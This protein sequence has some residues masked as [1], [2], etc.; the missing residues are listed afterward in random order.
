LSGGRRRR[1]QRQ[2]IARH[3]PS[4]RTCGVAVVG[5]SATIRL[6]P[7]E[8]TDPGRYRPRGGKRAGSSAG[9]GGWN[10]VCRVG[11]GRAEAGGQGREEGGWFADVGC[12]LEG[13][14]GGDQC[15]LAP[16]AAEE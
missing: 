1:R 7:R 6:L 2:I 5:S 10:V 8:Y 4:M 11:T 16:S 9:L 3:C 14:G 15:R 12:L 13:E